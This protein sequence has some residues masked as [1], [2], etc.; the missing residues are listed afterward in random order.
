MH[1][2]GRGES[3]SSNPVSEKVPRWTD[4]DEEEVKELVVKLKEEG[5][6]PSEIGLKLRDTYG[7]PSVKTLTGQ[8][9]TSILEDEGAADDIPE[10]LQNLL[11]T[12]ETMTEHLEENP[13]DLQ[14][15]RRL[16]LTEAKIRRLAKYH[17]ENGNIPEDWTYER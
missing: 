15:E 4:Y 9:I 6:S 5:R 12:A 7:I 3:G 17:R 2:D 1:S 13:N 10:D 8:K 16:E 11:D 14:T